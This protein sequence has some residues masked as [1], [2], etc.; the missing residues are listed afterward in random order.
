MAAMGRQGS[1]GTGLAKTDPGL[2]VAVPGLWTTPVGGVPRDIPGNP[3]A[4]HPRR[5]ILHVVPRQTGKEAPCLG[6]QNTYIGDPAKPR[7]AGP[8]HQE[9]GKTEEEKLG[10]MK[11]EPGSSW[12][13]L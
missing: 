9:A 8:T 2:L 7:S 1:T 4:T 11:A 6:H 13:E 5:D 3:N 10:E 12:E